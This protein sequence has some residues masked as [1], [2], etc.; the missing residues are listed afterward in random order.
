[1]LG[2]NFGR[3]LLFVSLRT[4]FFHHFDW[5]GNTEPSRVVYHCRLAVTS[6]KHL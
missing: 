6:E 3:A 4:S 2:N 5:L 1:M